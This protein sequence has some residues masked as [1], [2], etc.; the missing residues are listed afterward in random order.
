[1][2][3]AA[4]VPVRSFAEGKSRLASVLSM[5]ERSALVRRMLD[6]VL[7]A[8][9]SA[10]CVDHIIVVT[11]E[12]ETGLPDDIEVLNDEGLGLNE[13]VE[14]ATDALASRF[15]ASIIVA[16]DIPYISPEEIDS[17]VNQARGYDMVVVPDRR[18]EGTN[19]LWLRLPSS[20]SPQYGPHSAELHL[21]IAALRSLRAIQIEISGLSH[22]IDTPEDL[23]DE[24]ELVELMVKP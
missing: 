4:I 11:P 14:L 12:R 8:L 13:A 5:A 22:D 3:V 21:G 17:L 7:T 15:D 19:A 10:R 24:P 9:R 1:M 18:G 20:V 6:R 2:R 23:L 16:A